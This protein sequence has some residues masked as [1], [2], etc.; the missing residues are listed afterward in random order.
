MHFTVRNKMLAFV[1]LSFS[2]TTSLFADPPKATVV[3]TRSLNSGD[4]PPS[5][6]G[7]MIAFFSEAL[8]EMTV[9]PADQKSDPEADISELPIG[10]ANDFLVM[11]LQ[12]VRTADQM[13]IR[14]STG[15]ADVT[16][17]QW[18]D[19][20]GV[21]YSRAEI[22]KLFEVRKSKY[23]SGTNSRSISVVETLE[24]GLS[25][26][27]P[28]EESSDGLFTNF[29]QDSV[30][31]LIVEILHE[32]LKTLLKEP[33]GRSPFS[34]SVSNLD[35]AFTY[36][37]KFLQLQRTQDSDIDFF[38]GYLTYSTGIRDH[39]FS[40]LSSKMLPLYS[41]LLD[42]TISAP[43]SEWEVTG[44]STSFLQ[45]QSDLI[46][47]LLQKNDSLNLPADLYKWQILL[48][49][50]LHAS[51]KTTGRFPRN[52]TRDLISF[53]EFFQSFVLAHRQ[54]DQILEF[55]IQAGTNP[56][57]FENLWNTLEQDKEAFTQDSIVA[58]RSWL[59][60]VLSSHSVGYEQIATVI[61]KNEL[62][63]TE[64]IEQYLLGFM[65]SSIE[66]ATPLSQEG[67]RHMTEKTLFAYLNEK[68]R[69][70]SSGQ[71]PESVFD[72]FVNLNSSLLAKERNVE[73]K[74][75]LL[76][77]N[78]SARLWKAHGMVSGDRPV[79]I[80]GGIVKILNRCIQGF[81]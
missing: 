36:L 80:L 42:R 56:P 22:L 15:L 17:E 34:M 43:L 6:T 58:M 70:G 74:K 71:L 65:V 8:R 23:L 79:G 55:S 78:H 16:H 24:M 41:A 18:D 66:D 75:G 21:K 64:E 25:T 57:D 53:A 12:L 44:G 2:M 20:V 32:K 35:F 1:F 38:T 50:S 47:I 61:A 11:L 68:C 5:L 76:S 27:T 51:A 28:L 72:K 9:P 39:I 54:N 67:A 3:V 48:L 60:S 30:A 26:P 7:E 49:R 52:L 10:S 14:I 29:M 63:L 19:L 13:N 37:V 4:T 81:M 73:V 69:L 59:K 45:A 62:G 40:K 46:T 33:G 77:R 31:P